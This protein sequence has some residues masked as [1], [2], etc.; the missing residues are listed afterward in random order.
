QEHAEGVAVA[1]SKFDALA[2]KVG[3]RRLAGYITTHNPKVRARA[4]ATR[5]RHKAE[6]TAKAALAR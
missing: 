4:D 5:A 6:R 3:S 1:S 2:A